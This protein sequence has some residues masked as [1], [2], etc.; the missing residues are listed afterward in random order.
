[1][2]VPKRDHS[3]LLQTQS[4]GL[5][6]HGLRCKKTDLINIACEYQSKL[7]V[8]VLHWIVDDQSVFSA[9]ERLVVTGC[10]GFAGKR[11]IPKRKFIQ[12]ILQVITR[13]KTSVRNWGMVN[14]QKKI[15][16]VVPQHCYEDFG[17][18]ENVV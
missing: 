11:K 14:L 13:P 12:F 18:L 10:Y 5:D 3:V 7:C 1:M 2:A 16:K 17:W 4:C 6:F 8:Y 15:A 9:K